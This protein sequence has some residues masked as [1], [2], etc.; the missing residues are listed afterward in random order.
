MLSDHDIELIRTARHGDPFA[1]LGPHAD[2]AG[3]WWLRAM[4]PGASHVV[5]V[6]PD[7]GAAS[8]SGMAGGAS[9]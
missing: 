3:T 9:V 6:R 1:V 2:A 8:A 7:D 5:A 4:L